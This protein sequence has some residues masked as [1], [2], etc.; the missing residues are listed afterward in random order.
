[1]SSWQLRTAAKSSGYITAITDGI[2]SAYLPFL[3][4]L[5]EYQGH[6]IGIELVRRMLTILG[7]L[8]M[9]NDICDRALQSFYERFEM[10]APV[11]ITIRCF[12]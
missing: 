5:P 2:L 6:G 4:V 9:V 1:M 10:K 11:D 8:Y 12:D 3:E 7:N